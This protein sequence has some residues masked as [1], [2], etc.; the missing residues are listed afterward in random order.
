MLIKNPKLK[1]WCNLSPFYLKLLTITPF[2]TAKA[3]MTRMVQFCSL[4]RRIFAIFLFC[5][6]KIS[7]K[8]LGTA[9]RNAFHIFSQPRI[10]Q[11]AVIKGHNTSFTRYASL[12]LYITNASLIC[13]LINLYW[14]D[15]EWNVRTRIHIRTINITPSPLITPKELRAY[16]VSTVVSVWFIQR[17]S[18]GVVIRK[19]SLFEFMERETEGQNAVK[20]W[21]R[22]RPKA[23]LMSTGF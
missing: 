15:W 11:L 21:S 3:K 10:F 13:W 8:S 5:G 19:T 18:T 16:E 6:R 1:A 12:K 14:S 17:S 7:W 20:S 2:Q 23:G 4:R 22:E 9:G